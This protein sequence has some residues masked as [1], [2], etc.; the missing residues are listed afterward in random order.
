MPV[1]NL[2]HS[3]A[4]VQRWEISR[5]EYSGSAEDN[6]RS[7]MVGLAY[8]QPGLCSL[9]QAAEPAELIPVRQVEQAQHTHSD[10]DQV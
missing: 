1:A 5:I 7:R 6:Q 3:F 2:L 8:F 10:R 4:F 9:S